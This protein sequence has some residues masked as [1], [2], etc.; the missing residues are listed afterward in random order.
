MMKELEET[1]K[2]AETA[3]GALTEIETHKKKI[4]E[5]SKEISELK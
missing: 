3:N 4:E 5:Q 1:T 2:V